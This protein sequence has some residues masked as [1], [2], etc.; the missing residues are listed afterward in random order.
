MYIDIETGLLNTAEHLPSP[1]SDLRPNQMDIDLLVIHNISLP[2]R[3]FEGDHIELFFQNKLDFDAHPFY[4]QL[5]NLKVSAHLL[6]RRDGAIKQFVP[7]YHRA[8]H[9]GDSRFDGKTGC[10]D[11]SIGIELEGADDIPYTAV[12]YKQL[13]H[14]TKLLMKCFPKITLDR[15]VG[16]QDIAPVRK[17]DPGPAFDWTYYFNLVKK[18]G[19]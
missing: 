14:I 18:E 13:S 16:H 7:F 15:I 12:Q 17:T 8:R 6:I 2:P 5:I 19:G 4:Q 10:N 3:I 9:C 1:N 11:F